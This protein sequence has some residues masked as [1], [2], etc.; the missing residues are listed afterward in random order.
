MK[1]NKV[2]VWEIRPNYTTR[3]GKRSVRSYTVRWAVAGREHSET[4][5]RKTQADRY[6]SRLVSAAE[7]EAF[8]VEAGLP[9]SMAWEKAATTWYALACD[10]IDDRWPKIAG[11]GRVSVVEGLM[12]VTPVLVKSRRGAPDP[13][14]LRLALRNYAF[15]PPRRDAD[16][17]DE[18]AAALQ[19][20]AKASVPVSALEDAKT[21]AKALDACAT[22]LNGKPSKPQYYRRRRRVF[23][24]ALKYAVREKQL[25]A[26]PLANPDDVDW[27]PPEVVHEIDQ[28]RVPNPNQ[29]AALLDAIGDVGKT[30][31]PR[32][33]ALFGCMYYGM[34]RPSEAV[35]L[36]RDNCVS[37]PATG[38]GT[39]EL[40]RV[41]SAAGKQWTDDGEVHEER[42]LKGRA[43][44][45]RRPVPIPPELVT[46]LMAHLDAYGTA[47]D[48]RLFRPVGGLS[49]FETKPLFGWRVLVPRTKE[50]AE[51]LSTRLRGYGAVPDEV[52]TIS[53]EPPRTPQQMERAVKGLVTGRY[54]WVVFTSTNAVRAVRETTRGSVY[55]PST[56][57]QV[58]DKARPKALAAA[59]VKSPLARKPYD[60]RHA[61]VSWRLNAGVP[62]VYV[63]EWA[64][65]SVEV[66]QRTYAHCLDGDDGHWFA[67][68]DAALGR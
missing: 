24:G 59:Q 43:E 19:W 32:L 52:P 61:G 7:R 16:K 34:M 35:Y 50:Q 68:M 10:F 55:Q 47:A 65:H 31:G 29:V 15:N 9:D 41:M 39:L 44:G 58:L 51:S 56:L 22:N 12:A 63:A 1:S 38:W 67:R 13:K 46:L 28:R 21:V 30:Q 5:Q 11:K 49:W 33:V 42:G 14:T 8:D 60:F 64:G 17:P 20:V 40:E 4:F 18:I 2:R 36:R 25:S 57:W 53:V 37:L 6:K 45:T 66:L 3:N 54:E 27:K 48:G 26:N 23:Y 62:A